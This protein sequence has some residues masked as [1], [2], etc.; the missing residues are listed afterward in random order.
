MMT[1]KDV[2]TI[3]LT[4]SSL[5]EEPPVWDVPRNAGYVVGPHPEE[6]TL[7]VPFSFSEAYKISEKW[8]KFKIEE[9]PEDKW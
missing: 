8:G 7:F 1:C 2:K 3:N 4:V 9:M 5:T 6:C